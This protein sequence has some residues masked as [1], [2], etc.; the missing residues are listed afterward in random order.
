[1]P[2]SEEEEKR[3]Y[4]AILHFIATKLYPS[5]DELLQALYSYGVQATEDDVKK[6]V[7]KGYAEKNVWFTSVPKEFLEALTGEKL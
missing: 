1:M 3:R 4:D 6:A 2:W 5:M 7:K